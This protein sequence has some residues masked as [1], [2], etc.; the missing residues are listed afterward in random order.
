MLN[1]EFRDGLIPARILC[2]KIEFVD[3]L[4]G[5]L[6]KTAIAARR[7]KQRRSFDVLRLHRAFVNALLLIQKGCLP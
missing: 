2:G 7:E 3:T 5:P 4:A 1:R 6:D